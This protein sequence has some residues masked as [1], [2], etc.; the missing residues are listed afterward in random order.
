MR[1]VKGCRRAAPASWMRLSGS[2]RMRDGS[3]PSSCGIRARWVLPSRRQDGEARTLAD[4]C[5]RNPK[6][7]NGPFVPRLR[8]DPVSRLVML[9]HFPG[10][11][12]S[13]AP[14]WHASRRPGRR[15]SGAYV[16][17]GRSPGGIAT[18]RTM[19]LASDH[20]RGHAMSCERRACSSHWDR[21]SSPRVRGTPRRWSTLRST[22]RWPSR[23]SL[24]LASVTWLRLSTV[25]SAHQTVRWA[26]SCVPTP[27][28]EKPWPKGLS[29]R[30]SAGRPAL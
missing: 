5:T 19:V 17:Y 6:C 20:Q 25:V 26:A 14:G 23:A 21:T 1:N 12:R 2:I 9:S 8:A 13:C 30:K 11:I 3:A 22:S 15:T 7:R 16:N 18:A 4:G 28:L 27:G 10:H 24:P 29:P